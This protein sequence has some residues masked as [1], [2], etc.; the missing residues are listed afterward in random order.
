M[1]ATTGARRWSVVA[2]VALALT[3]PA[4]VAGS[5]VAD[6]PSGDIPITVTVPDLSDQPFEVVDAQLSWSVNAES[7]AGA[8]FGGCNFLM[9]GVPGATGDTGGGRV[10]TAADGLYRAQDGNVQ[11]EKPTA[12]GSLVPAT[13]DSRCTD[14][15]GVTVTAANG[16]TTESR[17]VLDGGTGDVDPRTGTARIRWTG[18]F[19]VVFYG[20]LTYWWASDP[21]LEIA[22][23]GTGRL[24]AT[25]GGFATSMEDMTKWAPLDETP[26]VLADLTAA[27]LGA[28]R[29]GLR[30]ANSYV[31]T[32]VQ[33]PAG[34]TA[35]VPRTTENA[36][37]WGSFPQSFVDF[38][39]LTGQL[40]YWYSSG[41]QADQRKPGASVLV[42]YDA[43]VPLT[44][45]DERPAA[46]PAGSG[47]TSALSS[48]S[49]RRAGAATSDVLA[50]PQERLVLPAVAAQTV[51]LDGPGLIPAASGPGD[52]AAERVAWGM[53]ALLLAGSGSVVGFRR[54]WLVLPWR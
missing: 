44:P 25:A 33:V 53:T 13:F 24:T 50:A 36:A 1:R 17:V 9:A 31:G 32:A 3:A 21:V 39:A 28:D 43:S 52:P 10:W 4:L 8:Y 41:G 30:A 12:D 5:A 26:V 11:I 35:Q 22:A 45:T 40:A 46:T 16:R 14:R 42:S 51:G 19:T 18:T 38:Q 7:G 29:Q 15:D 2:G 6:D 49:S 37:H 54:G 48:A 34:A 27:D 20:G 23:D 47:T